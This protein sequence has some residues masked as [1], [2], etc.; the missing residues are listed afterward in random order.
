MDQTLEVTE[1]GADGDPSK[2]L[3]LK[4]P[5]LIS[6]LFTFQTAVRSAQAPSLILDMTEVPY[7]DSAAVGVLVGAYVSRDKDGRHLLLVGV[8]PR[9]RAVLQVTQ[10]ERFFKFADKVPEGAAGA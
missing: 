1:I 10:V 9:V 8:N 3:H 4:G 5:L 6:N 7:V 2:I